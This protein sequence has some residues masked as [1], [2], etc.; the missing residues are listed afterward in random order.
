M[1][2]RLTAILAQCDEMSNPISCTFDAS[3]SVDACIGNTVDI[4]WDVT[5]LHPI[6]GVALVGEVALVVVLWEQVRCSKECD[7]GVIRV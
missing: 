4:A 6:M 5:A 2:A 7:W 3:K 1:P